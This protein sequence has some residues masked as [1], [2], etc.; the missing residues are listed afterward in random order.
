META[1]G[2]KKFFL[3]LRELPENEKKIVFFTIVVLSALLMIAFQIQASKRHIAKF[4]EAVGSAN[5]NFPE[6][7]SSAEEGLSQNDAWS[8]FPGGAGG[9]LGGEGDFNPSQMEDLRAL[10]KYLENPENINKLNDLKELGLPDG[11]SA[12]NNPLPSETGLPAQT[13]KEPVSNWSPYSNQELGFSINYPA[14]WNI[15]EK[16][17]EVYFSPESPEN[18]AEFIGQSLSIKVQSISGKPNL[19]SIAG[20]YLNPAEDEKIKIETEAVKIGGENGIKAK[21]VCEGVGCGAV[22]S[23]A[24]KNGKIFIFNPYLSGQK[25]IISTFKFID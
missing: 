21:A 8:A 14:G 13:D 11:F 15:K 4:R 23:F 7:N 24:A 2:I 9:D 22:W 16:D 6:L 1:T 5:L 10:E 12:A 20:Y 19:E 3:R 17:G 25:D 18:E